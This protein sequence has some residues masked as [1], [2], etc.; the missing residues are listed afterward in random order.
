MI[1]VQENLLKNLRFE[2]LTRSLFCAKK[3]WAYHLDKHFYRYNFS[4]KPAIAA[5]IFWD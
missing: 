5:V 4:Q 1:Y 2:I 3:E